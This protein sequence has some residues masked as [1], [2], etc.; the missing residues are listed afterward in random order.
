MRVTFALVFGK[1]RQLVVGQNSSLVMPMPCSPGDH[2]VQAARQ[3]HDARHGLVRGLQHIVVVA[4]DG[5]VGVH[6][7]VARVHVQRHPHAALEHALVDGRRASC[8]DGF[9]RRAGEMPPP[10]A[11]GFTSSSWR[12][13]CGLAAGE[14]FL[15]TMQPALPQRPH[16]GHQGLGLGR[17]VTPAGSGEYR[18]VLLA[19]RQLAAAKNSQ[20]HS[21]ICCAGSVRC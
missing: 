16:L 15:H 11:R 3:H 21:L 9:E 5:D 4:V 1:R 12:A 8:I 20:S 17:A 7:A 10:A 2:A 13:G 6:V 18:A 19:Q 14:Q